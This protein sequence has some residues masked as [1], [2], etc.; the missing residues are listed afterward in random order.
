MLRPADT[1]DPGRDPFE[2]VLQAPVEPDPVID[3]PPV[4]E[5]EDSMFRID[6]VL[7]GAS[8]RL[9]II[10]GT[11]VSEGEMLLGSGGEPLGRVVS[12]GQEIV[13]VRVGTRTYDI[14]VPSAARSGL[15]EVRRER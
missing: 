6:G 7:Q 2:P 14:K 1:W 4:E 10:N 13:Q 15:W 5:I 12:I 3:V 11:V 8:S 9:A